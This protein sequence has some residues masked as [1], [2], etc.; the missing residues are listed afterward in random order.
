MY[1]IV[2]MNCIFS[3]IT[4]ESIKVSSCITPIASII[5]GTAYPTVRNELKNLRTLFFLYLTEKFIKI[6]RQVHKRAEIIAK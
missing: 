2:N 1:L 3:P 5:P 6:A 4:L